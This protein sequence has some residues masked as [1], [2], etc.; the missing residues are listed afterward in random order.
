M[1]AALLTSSTIMGLTADG[2]YAKIDCLELFS[3]VQSL[4]HPGGN[5]TGF[6]YLERT[7]GAKWLALLTEIAPRVKHDM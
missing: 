6:A 7:T 4:A 2:N 5:I 1:P 3:F